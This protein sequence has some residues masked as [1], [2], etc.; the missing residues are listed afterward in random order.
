MLD[1]WLQEAAAALKVSPTDPAVLSEETVTVLLDLARDAA[2]GVARPAAP[3]GTFVLGLAL[4]ASGGGM[5]DLRRLAGRL[6]EL[7]DAWEAEPSS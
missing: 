3:L 1:V 4:G 5:D 2:H 6:T 7:A